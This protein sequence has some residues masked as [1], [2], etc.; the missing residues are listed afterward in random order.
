MEFGPEALIDHTALRR[1]LGI[2]RRA[3]AGASVWAVVKADAYGHGMTAAA[4]ALGEA[5]GLAVARVEEAVRLREAGIGLPLLVLEGAFTGEELQLAGRQNLQLV[6]HHEFQIKLLERTQVSSP[7]GIWIKIDTGMHRLG[8]SPERGREVLGRLVTAVALVGRPGWLT[9][10]ACAD[11]PG[12]PHT[13]VQ[14]QRFQALLRPGETA[15]LANSAAILSGMAG[16]RE[17]IRPGIMLYGASPFPGETGAQRGLEPVMTLQARLI[18]V[19]RIAAGERVGYGGLY[20]CPRDMPVGVIGIGYGDGY[21]RQVTSGT[22]VL[23]NGQRVPLVGRV[24]MDMISV[25]LSP[26]PEA[27]VGDPAVLWGRGLPVE[28]IAER[29]GTISYQLLCGVTAR[30]PRRYLASQDEN[31]GAV[32]RHRRELG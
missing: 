17:W 4:A 9:H 20:R 18:A 10:L 21:P 3:S 6:V 15:S 24:S 8:F 12:H 29:A 14:W 32:V 30:V 2:A 23:V 22:P 28:E 26:C 16:P 11:E 1:N 5:D 31:Q 25:D 7:L 27:R 19:N 13:Q